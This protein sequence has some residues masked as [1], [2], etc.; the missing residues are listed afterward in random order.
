MSPP[1]ISTL[2]PSTT[3]LTAVFPPKSP[4]SSSLSDPKQSQSSSSL[5]LVPTTRRKAAAGVILTSIVSL[6]HFLHQPPVATAFS[7]GISGPKDW[8]REQ[9]KKASK[10]LLAPIDASRNSLQA[11]YLIITSGTSPE[12]DLEEVQRLLISASRDCIPQER[13]SIVTFQS[14]TGVE[15]C[16]FKLVLKN[17]ASLLEDTDPTKVEAEAKLTDL[18]RSLSSLNTVANGTS[19]RLVSDRQKVADALMDTIS[20]LNKFEQ[21]VKDCLEI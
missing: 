12:K 8:L 9:K 2:I 11:A 21:G 19:P 1:P 7:L 20:S 5:S 4:Q 13:N 14:N 3:I 17:A 6:I 10:Y 18:E 15:V 16:T